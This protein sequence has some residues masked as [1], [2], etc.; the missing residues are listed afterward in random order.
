[1]KR[2]GCFWGPQNDA[3]FAGVR[4]LRIIY[5]YRLSHGSVMGLSVLCLHPSKFKS[6][7]SP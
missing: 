6:G 3:M 7:D 5:V 1:M 2:K 4:F